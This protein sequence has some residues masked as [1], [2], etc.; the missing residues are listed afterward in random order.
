MARSEFEKR[1]PTHN[2]ATLTALADNVRRL[3]VDK[4]WTQDELAAATQI[5]Q[6]MLSRIENCRANPTIETLEVIALALG[7]RFIDLF[8]SQTAKR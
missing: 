2:S 7:V 6:Q 5:D 3:R 4:G 8:E 1:F